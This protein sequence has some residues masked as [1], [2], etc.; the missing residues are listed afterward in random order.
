MP[1]AGGLSLSGAMSILGPESRTRTWLRARKLGI[2]TYIGRSI[3]DDLVAGMLSN[4]RDL[5]DYFE[6]F[7][8]SPPQAQVVDRSLTHFETRDWRRHFAARLEGRGLELG[9]LHR[10]I[11]PHAGMTISYVDRTDQK[12]LQET[13][14]T[15]ARKIGPVDVIDD[16]ETLSTVT[17]GSYDFLIAAHVIEHMRNPIG[18]LLHWLRVVRDG[19]FVYLVVPDKRS[20]FDKLRVRTT[21]EH[22]V[23]D[24]ERPSKER[25]FEHFLDYALFVHHA[26]TDQAIGEAQRLVDID[27]SIHFHVFL[28]QD[29]VRLVQWVDGHVTPVSVVEGPAMSPGMDEFH[30]LLRKGAHA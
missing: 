3:G 18:S 25:D 4:R 30:L 29:V 28:P 10:P 22:M 1:G 16:A 12:T 9:P 26:R 20:T 15:L 11:E 5:A 14:P 19:G 17:D 21:L 6:Q 23:L 8:T 24:Y 2:L 27:Y 13:F 7:Q